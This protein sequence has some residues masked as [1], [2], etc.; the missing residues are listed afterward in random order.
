[1]Q[2]QEYEYS[3]EKEERDDPAYAN[4]LV[5][6]DSM[7]RFENCPPDL[8]DEYLRYLLS[9]FDLAPQGKTVIEWRGRTTDGKRA[10]L[11]FVVRFASAAWARAAVRELQSMQIGGKQS[12]D[13][14]SMQQARKQS[15]E[16]P[17]SM[18]IGRKSIKLSAYPNQIRYEEESSSNSEN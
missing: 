8:T 2:V 5:V 16:L 13:H 7:V 11:M 12:R 17:Q 18:Q 15:R 14:Q 1:V 3:K 4:G 6:D 9:R 10:P